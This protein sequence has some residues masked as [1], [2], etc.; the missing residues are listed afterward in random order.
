MGVDGSLPPPHRLMRA[1]TGLVANSFARPALELFWN[2][3]GQ[4]FLLFRHFFFNNNF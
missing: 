2:R 3:E 4:L 1:A